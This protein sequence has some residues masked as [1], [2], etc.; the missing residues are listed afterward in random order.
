MLQAHSGP[1]FIQACALC[2][3]EVLT[4]HYYEEP[5]FWIADCAYC[6]IPMVVLRRHTPEASPEELSLMLSMGLS[7]FPNRRPDFQRKS[8][9]E[10]Q[11]FH[12][13]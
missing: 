6:R 3:A 7:L 10:H 4:Y 2:R 8:I 13:R 9:P 5:L 11:H 1:S 12:L